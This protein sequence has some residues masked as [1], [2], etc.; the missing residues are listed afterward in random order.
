MGSAL[1]RL[2]EF[3]LNLLGGLNDLVCLSSL[4]LC[5]LQ[6]VL[7]L[8]LLPGSLAGLTLDLHDCVFMELGFLEEDLVL[9]V[10]LDGEFVL[11]RTQSQLE[12]FFLLDVLL[13]ELVE[14]LVDIIFLESV[15]S[16]FL[17]DLKLV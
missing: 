8:A 16:F 3:G 15:D 9:L 17:A 14:L 5:P 1:G 13:F 7:E 2:L 6:L 12:K 11:L 4:L 10:H